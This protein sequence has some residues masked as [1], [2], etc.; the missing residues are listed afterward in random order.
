MKELRNNI[1]VISFSEM[2][3]ARKEARSNKY[4]F[5]C[6]VC[7]DEVHHNKGN[8]AV[9]DM[10]TG[11]GKC[12][13]CGAKFILDT[14]YEEWCAEHLKDSKNYKAPELSKLIDS[15]FPTD[16][17]EFFKKRG[18]SL[19]TVHDLG[20]KWCVRTY[21]TKEE[22]WIAYPSY[23]NG[24]IFCIQYRSPKEKKFFMSVGTKPMPF[25][26]DAAI[27]EETIIIVE[28]Q[29][30]VIAMQEAGFSNVISPCNGCESKMSQFEELMNSNFASVK[31]VVFAGDTDEAGLK[32]RKAIFKLFG[33]AR[34]SVCD[35]EYNPTSNEDLGI[36]SEA[37]A[38]KDA[39]E[40]LL[41]RGPEAIEWCIAHAWEPKIENVEM[42]SD[43]EA[44]LDAYYEE[45]MPKG[46]SAKIQRMDHLV[47]FAPDMM[48]VVTGYPGCGKSTWVCQ[49]ASS[50]S[51][52][53][54]WK[55][56]YFSPENFPVARHLTQMVKAITGKPFD[57]MKMP[58]MEYE[59]CKNYLQDNIYHISGN[60]AAI[61]DILHAAEQLIIRHD[62]K[63]LVLD[64]F[65]YIDLPTIPGAND[66]QKI[67]MVLKLIVL[68]THKWHIQTII[69]AHPR[70]PGNDNKS[71]KPSEFDIAGSQ[72]FLNKADEVLI[73]YRDTTKNLTFV[74]NAKCRYSELGQLGTIALSYNPSNGRFQGCKEEQINDKEM[75]Y[76]P[77]PWDTSDWL[78]GNVKQLE[79]FDTEDSDLPF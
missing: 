36:S 74:R 40:M 75:L 1:H 60:L 4:T 2:T 59:N 72:D 41:E 70:K 66:T 11:M 17:T 47:R 12:F 30:D 5:K 13:S 65:N 49:I 33:E 21:G 7:K 35:W 64:P 68:F 14:K 63:L 50:L 27:G 52:N 46:Y 78:T 6:P 20:V 42:V 22:H 55:V 53:Y 67:S 69:V 56:A 23:H 32:F 37:Y 26:A 28:G 58:K 44:A 29:N 18:V 57:K 76:T 16:I 61:E 9:M 24:E 8:N 34:C 62:I 73:L 79:M 43:T 31:H 51:I 3:N 19:K 77:L 25:N 48:H 71:N 54:H 38:A 15:S 45:G 39:N 10:D